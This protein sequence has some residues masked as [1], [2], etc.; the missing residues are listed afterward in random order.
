MLICK[1]LCVVRSYL[2]NKRVYCLT[3]YHIAHPRR[4]QGRRERIRVA[5]YTIERSME[6]KKIECNRSVTSLTHCSFRTSVKKPLANTL[7]H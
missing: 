6:C 4:D 1:L 5:Y 2:C 3:T 7:S